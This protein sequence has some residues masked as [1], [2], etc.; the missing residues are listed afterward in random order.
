MQRFWLCPQQVCSHLPVTSVRNLNTTVI[1]PPPPEERYPRA[2]MAARRMG[3]GSFS[4]E[5]WGNEEGCLRG[6]R[7]AETDHGLKDVLWAGCPVQE[8]WKERDWTM[9][10]NGWEGGSEKQHAVPWGH[11]SRVIL[12][13]GGGLDP[14]LSIRV[15]GLR[16]WLCHQLCENSAGHLTSV[17]VASGIT[18]SSPKAFSTRIYYTTLWNF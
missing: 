5:T 15:W 7:G 6:N 10:G 14:G 12:T 1:T 18:I 3:K 4:R 2:E 9:M 16:P 8:S 11:W 17:C 13:E